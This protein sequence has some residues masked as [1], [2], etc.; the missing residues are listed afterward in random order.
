[1][2]S[3]TGPRVQL[4]TAM[5]LRDVV[6]FFITAGTNLQWV[7]TAAAAGTSSITAWLVTG[8]AML[9]P[10]AYCIVDLSSRYPQEGG[11]YVWTKRA[12]GD[13]AGF[14]TGWTY[15]TSNLPYFPGVLY[16][17]ASNALF[18]GPRGWRGLADS[19][20][21]FI[22][23]SLLGLALGTLL[24]VVGLDVGKWL[25]NAGAV[26]RW[27]ATLALIGIGAM[28]W[29]QLGSATDWSLA[30]LRPRLGLRDL[31]FWSTLAF[32]WTGF[33]A[34]SFMGDE[35]RDAR[36]TIPRAIF[37]SAPLIALIYIAGTASVLVA[38]PVAEVSALQG[39]IQAIERAAQRIDLPM[40]TPVV[41]AF[42]VVTA[43]GSVGAWLAAVARI[44]FVVGV[45]RYLPQGFA[46]LHPRWGSPHIAL[47]SQTLITVVF[48]FLGQAGTSVKGAYNAL[49]S[50]AVIGTLLPFLLVFASA[51]KLQAEPA[52]AGATRLPGGRP[53]VVAL[54]VLGFC[55]TVSSI[56]LSAFPAQDEANKPL[57]VAKVLGL[58][59]VMVG[60]GV[61]VYVAG[62]RRA[63]AATRA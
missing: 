61:L 21:Y 44:P 9:L 62:R 28:A 2:S 40:L 20:A 27:L 11:I 33:E 45:D 49:V 35:I 23:A 31:I 37:A 55:T 1:M 15:W 50:L 29:L 58:T 51:I 19:P 10:M 60:A 34:A 8:V 5:G 22:L 39:I 53:A 47:L 13:F 42:I 24:N 41:A 26:C 7:A 3:Q 36:R 18:I 6:L 30:S 59:C 17:A 14:I 48:V 63:R 56:I 4:R 46:R 57:A 16:F 43:L 12:F 54:A 38:L 32:A 52:P 25:T